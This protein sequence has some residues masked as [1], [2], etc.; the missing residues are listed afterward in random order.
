MKKKKGTTGISCRIPINLEKDLKAEA[1]SRGL[2]QSEYM[3]QIIENRHNKL[4]LNEL[5]QLNNNK[6]IFKVTIEKIVQHPIE[7]IKSNFE[8]EKELFDGSDG[9]LDIKLI[10][11]EKVVSDD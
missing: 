9:F 7:T 3:R 6:P 8:S 11:I 5:E 2:T 1:G 4:S 10:K